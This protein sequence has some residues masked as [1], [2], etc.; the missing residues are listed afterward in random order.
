MH[1]ETMKASAVI[2]EFGIVRLVFP[3]VKLAPAGN[4]DLSDY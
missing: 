4:V 2:F 3:I 1:H